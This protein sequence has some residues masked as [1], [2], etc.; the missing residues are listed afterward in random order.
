[1]RHVRRSFFWC[2][3]QA[4]APRVGCCQIASPAGFPEGLS[5]PRYSRRRFLVSRRF[6][7][8]LHPLSIFYFVLYSSSIHPLFYPLFHSLLHPLF[9]LCS[10]SVRPLC[11]L[12]VS[13]SHPLL[14]LYSSSM[15]PLCILFSS[16]IIP[17][18]ILYSILYSSSIRPL[19]LLLSIKSGAT[20]WYHCPNYNS[21][22]RTAT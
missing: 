14:F 2:R 6:H 1:M 15:C 5:G 9:I 3:G 16:Y 4:A 7:P 18:F 10:S 20:M 21:F 19:M 17:S 8:L 12:G 11:I 22:P 13:S